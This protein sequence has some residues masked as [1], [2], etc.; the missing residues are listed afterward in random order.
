M[1]INTM[2]RL[3]VGDK[4]VKV[5]KHYQNYD[6]TRVP[7]QPA[8]YT[9]KWQNGSEMTMEEDTS[10]PF[11]HTD[12]KVIY[13]G[14]AHGWSNRQ[15]CEDF[16]TYEDYIKGTYPQGIILDKTKYKN[17]EEFLE[18]KREVDYTRAK[19]KYDERMKMLKEKY[20]HTR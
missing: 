7:C 8:V 2:K 1:E 13:G 6:H 10:R 3:K 20:P 16:E 17:I 5:R 9:I 12:H 15:I 19:K 18:V 11:Y 4:I 14:S